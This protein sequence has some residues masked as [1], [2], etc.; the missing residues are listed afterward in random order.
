MPTP[1]ECWGRLSRALGKLAS[2]MGRFEPAQCP[3]AERQALALQNA[4]LLARSD[5]HLAAHELG[6]LLAENG[7]LLASEQVLRQVAAHAP[8]PTVYRNLAR[9][10]RRLGRPDLAAGSENQAAV[11]AAQMGGDQP[12]Q[13]VSA[14]ALARTPDAMGPS[15][16][17][18]RPGA[19]GPMTARGPGG[20]IR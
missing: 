5:N 4:A 14:D 15:T 17:P 10:E 2:R 20:M 9:V 1:S 13:W 8:H 18:P 19:A 3:L 12:V 11:L 16:N 7:H 6:V